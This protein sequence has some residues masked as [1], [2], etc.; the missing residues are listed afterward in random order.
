M[1]YLE[2]EFHFL[3]ECPLYYDLR[4]LLIDKYYWKHHSMITFI[5]L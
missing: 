2:D 3:L 1:Q 4:K 5:D